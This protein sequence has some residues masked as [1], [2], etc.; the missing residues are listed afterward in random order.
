[1]ENSNGFR[2]NT[3]QPSFQA[4]E[5]DEKK[6]LLAKIA[7][8]NRKLK[9]ANKKTNPSSSSKKPSKK[10]YSGYNKGYDQDNDVFY[11]QDNVK[12][13]LLLRKMLTCSDVGDLGRILLPKKKE[14]LGAQPSSWRKDVSENYVSM[15]LEASEEEDLSWRMFIEEFKDKEQQWDSLT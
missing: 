1:M 6:E 12:L 3:A 10:I 15:M 5:H 8:A 9:L 11:T 7:R 14:K 13:S 4:T 2:L